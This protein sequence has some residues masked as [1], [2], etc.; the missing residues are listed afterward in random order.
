[1]NSE[2]RR[3]WL[4]C[5]ESPPYFLHRHGQ[6]YDATAKA[7]LPFY[8]WPAQV[9]VLRAIQR[10]RLLVL[11]KARQLGMTWLLLG[12]ALW[13]MLFRPAATELIFSKRDDEAVNLLDERLKGMYRR[14]PAYLQARAVVKDNEH[15]W[16]LSN[17]S[18]ALAF[19]TTGGDSYTATTVIADEF[20]LV[21][22]QGQLLAAVKP[23]I[24]AGGRF[25]LL[26][27]VDKS[28]PESQFKQ[29]YRAAR[30]GANDWHPLFLPWT[31]RPGRTPDWYDAQKRDIEA[32]T[33]SLDELH[34][35]YPATDTE[36]LAPRSLDKRI[37]PAWLANCYV[38]SNG[39]TDE[40]L[41]AAS[42][43]AIPGLVVFKAPVPARRY[44]LG[45]DPAEGNPTSDDSAL[46]VQDLLT[47]EEVAALAGKLQPAQLAAYADQL[48]R[49][50]NG[51]DLMVERNN[52]GHAVI[53]WL[54]ANSRLRVLA[55]YDNRPGWLSSQ[56][57][58]TLL[59]DACAEAFRD[60]DTLV[61]SFPAYLQLASIEGATLRAP[62]G[63]F[64]DRADAYALANLG[65]RYAAASDAAAAGPQVIVH[66]DP[67]EISAF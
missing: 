5:S 28:K 31:A 12:F 63:Q 7:W 30:A 24:D 25:L 60:K 39:L 50:F 53:L 13:E 57:G 18:A 51:A 59:Y 9:D 67:V 19:P 1:M 64:D 38:E 34:E 23:T 42:A 14:L 44:V 56:L 2:E 10:H 41:T 6:V 11:L 22:N 17:G 55:G 15:E 48:G 43:P 35:Q 61:H 40:Q 21:P 33:G 32:R 8:L 37:A 58:K 27:R 66:D 47:G 29:I 3:E 45:A 65:R 54:L 20:D 49:Y 36:A 4:R 26:S 16:R 52:H 62:E 46:D